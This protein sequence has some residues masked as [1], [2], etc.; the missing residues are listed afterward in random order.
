MRGGGADQ[1]LILLDGAEIYNPSHAA[2]FISIFNMDM[3]KDATLYKGGFP[4]KYGGRIS[5]ILDI[6]RKKAI[7]KSRNQFGC[8]PSHKSSNCLGCD[9]EK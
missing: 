7:L 4:A 2:G 8:W 5:S 9:M 6:K 3:I 1:N